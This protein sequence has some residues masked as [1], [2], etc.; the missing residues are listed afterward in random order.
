MDQHGFTLEEVGS[1]RDGVL[2]MEVSF[3]CPRCQRP[4]TVE[5]LESVT[6]SE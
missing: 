3:S 5:L 1:T 4:V 6:L 2:Y